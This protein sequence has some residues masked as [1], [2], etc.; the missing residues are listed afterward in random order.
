MKDLADLKMMQDAEHLADAVWKMVI[1]WSAFAKDTLG[2][3]TVKA[4]DS[5]GANIAESFGRF[6][7]GEKLQFLYYA[8]GSVF[9]S[10]YWLNRALQR[11]LISSDMHQ[12]YAELLTSIARQINGFARNMKARR[13]TRSTP[14]QLRESPPVYHILQQ[15]SP[16]ETVIFSE[17]QLQW[18]E[19][20]FDA[21]NE[22]LI[23]IRNNPLH[24]DS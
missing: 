19:T 20:A 6:H 23:A 17:F 18:L 1:S 4:A 9:E 13:S 10:R 21:D 2:V 15:E 16:E 22:T 3:Q 5:I 8:R 7:Y 12:S 24:T 14:M 11:R